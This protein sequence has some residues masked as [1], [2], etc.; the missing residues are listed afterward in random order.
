LRTGARG[1]SRRGFRSPWHNGCSWPG[2]R[3]RR[4]AKR[5]E[6]RSG[7][8]VGRSG[9]TGDGA[10]VESASRR[11][12]A[13]VTTQPGGF[14]CAVGM[15]RG[16]SPLTG[17]PC[18]QPMAARE[19]TSGVAFAGPVRPAGTGRGVHE[20][21]VPRRPT[22]RWRLH[23]SAEL[24]SGKWPAQWSGLAGRRR[25]HPNKW[26]RTS[27]TLGSEWLQVSQGAGAGAPWVQRYGGELDPS[28]R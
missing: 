7:W 15:S 8:V 21:T 25:G 18:R 23:R 1:R 20:R 11:N 28:M 14:S 10:P 12:V 9:R 4:C 26:V 2:R 27:R 22:R 3:H 17:W 6:G 16:P 5:R 19:E 24:G 13:L